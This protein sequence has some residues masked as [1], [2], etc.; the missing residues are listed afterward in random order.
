[1][2][3]RTK[4]E[5]EARIRH[6]EN[7]RRNSSINYEDY[8]HFS[9][10]REYDALMTEYLNSNHNFENCLGNFLVSSGYEKLGKIN[11]ITHGGLNIYHYFGRIIMNL[12]H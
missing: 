2:N 3:K 6:Q 12:V 5:S 11:G 9:T 8:D 1:M 10:C 7:I 4:D